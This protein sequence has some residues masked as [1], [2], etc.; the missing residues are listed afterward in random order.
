MACQS[1]EN[2]FPAQNKPDE[3]VRVGQYMIQ[4]TRTVK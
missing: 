4:D 3:I 1:H 2:L